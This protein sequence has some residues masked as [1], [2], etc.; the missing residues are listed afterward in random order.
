MEK[1][2]ADILKQVIRKRPKNSFKGTYGKI[3]L[4]G[5]SKNFGGAIIMATMAAVY[6]G[7]GLVTTITDGS[8]QSSLHSLLP[9]AMFVDWRDEVSAKPILD[10]ATV[11][12]VGPGLGT[13]P[14]SLRLLK[15]VLKIAHQGQ[16]LVIDGSALTLM[17]KNNLALPKG[18][19]NVLTPHQMEWQRISGVKIADQNPETNLAAANKLNA[20]AV[21]KSSQTEVFINGKGYQNTSGSPAQAVGGMGDTLA[22]IVGGFTAQFEDTPKAVLA[23]VYT[24]SAIA[25]EIAKDHYIVLPHQISQALPKFMFKNQSN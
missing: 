9:E 6:S 8:N 24:H 10:A 23:A 17:A 4:V 12:V 14:Y 1:I 21:V 3:A 5:G 16:V 13:Q 18:S 15:G 2:T 25:D 7:A 20:I 22:G 19:L 11:I